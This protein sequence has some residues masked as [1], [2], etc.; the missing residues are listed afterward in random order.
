MYNNIF[1][2]YEKFS[3]LLHLTQMY[4]SWFGLHYK[5]LQTVLPICTVCLDFPQTFHIQTLR[6]LLLT[7][8][9]WQL[10]NEHLAAHWCG[11]E[12]CISHWSLGGPAYNV[13]EKKC[14]DQHLV[15]SDVHCILEGRK[16]YFQ[17]LLNQHFFYGYPILQL[18]G[19]L[20]IHNYIRNCQKILTWCLNE[21]K[22][23]TWMAKCKQG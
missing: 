19:C 4:Q 3:Y 16:V 11:W 2:I 12:E 8:Y 5:N 7:V 6:Q 14:H 1:S 15:H 18:H 10:Q 17:Y 9:C 20:I 23:V 21:F 22:Y 13:A